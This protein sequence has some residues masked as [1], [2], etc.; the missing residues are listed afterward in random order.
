MSEIIIFSFIAFNISLFKMASTFIDKV[1]LLYYYNQYNKIYYYYY[2][3]YPLLIIFYLMYVHS[4]ISVVTCIFWLFHL[5]NGKFI[6]TSLFKHFEE[7]QKKR[8]LYMLP[9]ETIKNIFQ[10]KTKISQETLE[11][12][13]FL[14]LFEYLVFFNVMLELS[15]FRN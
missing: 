8:D 15:E 7:E 3:H 1:S 10:E 2:Q 12:K 5:F 6:E 9:I 11:E 4:Y 14:F 13:K